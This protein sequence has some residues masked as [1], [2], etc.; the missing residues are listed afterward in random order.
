VL[1]V[2]QQPFRLSPVGEGDPRTQQF[3]RHR[4]SIGRAAEMLECHRETILDVRVGRCCRI[5]GAEVGHRLVCFALS[6]QDPS[7]RVL[8]LRTCRIGGESSLRKL[9]P[10]RQIALPLI[11][12]GEVVQRSRV[13]RAFGDEARIFVDGAVILFLLE[14]EPGQHQANG[15]SFGSFFNRPLRTASALARS[16]V[17]E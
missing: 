13:S 5:G 8:D 14:I 2:L 16:S 11:K 10:L 17:R 9:A 3:F 4:L 12:P 15:K 1:Q 7:Q 6:Q